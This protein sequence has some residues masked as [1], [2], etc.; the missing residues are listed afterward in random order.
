M[1]RLTS[2]R[3][4]TAAVLAVRTAAAETKI[5]TPNAVNP[6]RFGRFVPSS[7]GSNDMSDLPCILL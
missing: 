4:L 3:I 6:L 5:L 7:L 2:S 1:V